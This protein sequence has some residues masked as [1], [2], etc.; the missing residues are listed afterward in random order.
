[1]SQCTIS[2]LLLSQEMSIFRGIRAG[3]F[4]L[5]CASQPKAKVISFYLNSKAIL[6]EKKHQKKKNFFSK[7]LAPKSSWV[8]EEPKNSNNACCHPCNTTFSLSNIGRGA[9]VSHEN[10]KNTRT[11]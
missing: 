7:E 1:M 8:R 9:L 5:I 3:V 6:T 2:L 10:N 4:C 11:S